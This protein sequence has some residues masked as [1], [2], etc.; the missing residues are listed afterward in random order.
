MAFLSL[1][2]LALA[3]AT[4]A[5]QTNSSSCDTIEQGYTCSPEIS[6]YWGQ[7]SPYFSVPSNISAD[8]PE[9]CTLTFAQVLSRHGAR[10][11][12]SGKTTKYNDT[13]S[14]IQQNAQSFAGKAAF[15][16]D[17]TYDLGADELT[18]FGETELYNSG[19]KFY[20]RYQALARGHRL[21]VRASAQSRVVASGQHFTEGFHAAM[22]ADKAANRSADFPY[23]LHP[24]SEAEDQNN[25]MSHA[26]CTAFENEDDDAISARGQGIYSDLVFPAI[27]ARVNNEIL[28][29]ANLTQKETSY[30][31]DLC[32]FYTVAD[33]SGALSPFC[34]LF[35]EHE[36]KQYD[37]YQTLGK[38]YHYG[39][40]D[41]LGPTQGVGYAN[42]LAARLTRSPVQDRTSSNRTRDA[43]PA[44]FPLGAND[45]LFAD[46]S[47]DNDMTAAFFALGLFNATEPLTPEQ[48]AE[49][50]L[51]AGYASAWTVPF[52]ARLYVE[53][54]R[55]AEGEEE[56][57]RFVLND[58]VLPLGCADEN[59]A[60]KLSEFVD[61]LAF[62][63]SGGKWDQCFE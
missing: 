18:A 37:Y 59:G 45:R 31:M 24:V 61:G 4:T 38:Y 12:T 48:R 13:I 2:F 57:V 19:V 50:A 58:R 42:E 40:G 14:K 17:F 35:T 5:Q 20:E 62:A 47:H 11:P 49:P 60:C 56:Y 30:L 15:L 10:D 51:T 6:H 52:A 44:F 27:T 39:A 53:A 28:P 63:R 23:D 32:P 43:D 1:G 22:Q 34:A 9:T 8:I 26:L 36:W 54:F 25:T 7:Y 16:K 3:L 21:F 55:C 33:P 41:P 29:G 46:F